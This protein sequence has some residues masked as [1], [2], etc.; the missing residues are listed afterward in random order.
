MPRERWLELQPPFPPPGPPAEARLAALNVS[1]TPDE[2]MAALHAFLE[3][4]FDQPIE[5]PSAPTLLDRIHGWLAQLPDPICQNRLVHP[6]QADGTFYVA[7]DCHWTLGPGD[8]VFW[9]MGGEI[10][11]EAEP[12]SGFLIQLVLFEA[13]MSAPF[14]ASLP[15]WRPE[16][17]EPLRARF[18]ELPLGTWYWPGDP[19][20]FYGRD[21]ALLFLSEGE[22]QLAARHPRTLDFA[23][24]LVDG[25]WMSVCF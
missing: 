1:G 4:W 10:R 3:G 11:R 25:D 13:I 21:G 6:P 23:A 16:A 14:G 9:H 8:E 7:N 22:A 12:L 20:R 18:R 19:A 15:W 17:I 2:R 24:D 5:N